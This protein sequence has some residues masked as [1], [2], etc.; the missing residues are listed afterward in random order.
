MQKF[1]IK[2]ILSI[3]SD[4][5][6][7]KKIVITNKYADAEI[8][9]LGG[10]LTHFQ[11]K[12]EE[13]VIFD[14]KKSYILPNKSAHFGI[15]ICWPWFGPHPTDSTLPQHGFARN[16]HWNILETKSLSNAETLVKLGLEDNE[17]TLAL[18]PHTFKLE[19]TF[20]LGKT[21]KVELKT[22]NTSSTPMQLTQALHSY[23]YVNNIR[24]IM[25]K[26]LENTSFIDQL[27]NNKVKKEADSLQFDTTLDR[28]YID[29]N[30]TCKIIDPI[31]KRNIIVEKRYSKSTV[32]WN[33]WKDNTL[34]DIG[35]KKYIKFVCVETANTKKGTIILQKNE[36][37][38]LMQKISL[39]EF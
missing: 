37:C 35:D 32:I 6:I 26:G 1:E 20:I 15:P 19:L 25:I 3:K 5:N 4:N 9:L 14:G 13:K 30:K 8:Y 29:T 21:L 2:N 17:D 7:G 24:D 12:G 28:I 38:I 36:S 11:P 22:T 34:H 31:L 18:F 27:D 39:D 33:P 10:N 16:S 23:F